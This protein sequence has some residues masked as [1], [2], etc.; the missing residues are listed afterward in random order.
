MLGISFPPV[1]IF[2]SSFFG[3]ALTIHLVL[4]SKNYRQFFLR[5][6]FIFTVEQLIAIS[7]I[8]ISGLQ[9]HAD[10]FL[11]L[12]G[13]VTII[14]HSLFL[15][16][17][18]LIFFFVSRNIKISRFP[19]FPL[20]FFPFIW[21]AF[22]YFH[23]LG[24]VSFPW[25]TLGNAFTTQLNKIQFTE[26]TGVFGISFWVCII[27]ALIYYLVKES[28]KIETKSFIPAFTRRKNIIIYVI[29]IV[30]Y[31]LPDI[32]SIST[33]SH[34]KYTD[35]KK[36][37]VLK[38]GV[39]QPNYNPWTKWTMNSKTMTDEYAA[40]IRDLTSA[41]KNLDLIVMP[42]ASINYYLLEPY[43]EPKL[44]IFTN[45]VDS[46]NI[47]LLCGGPDLKIWTDTLSAPQDAPKYNDSYKYSSY[48]G[49]FLIEKGN[50]V[51]DIQKYHKMRLVA[52]S[53]RIPHQEYLKFLKNFI[54]WEVGISSYEIGKDTTIFKLSG[55]NKFNTAIC[56]ESIYPDF[57]RRFVK[58]G[59]EFSVV[60]T[61]DGW[62]GK[63]FGTY[64]HNQFAILRAVENRRWIV[65][66][67]NTGISC[68]IDPYGNMTNKTEIGERVWFA[69]EI[70]VNNAKTFYTENGDLIGE[71]SFYLTLVL[72][73]SG[74][75]MRIYF[76]VLRRKSKRQL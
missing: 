11:A 33:S 41:N 19:N 44:R 56:Y 74:I 35:Y 28:R 26:Y 17:P 46:L 22:E 61:N 16:I 70:G 65:R 34:D 24:E 6:Y 7:W 2:F 68:I 55:K 14:I 36:D 23:S 4:D 64:Q 69:S 47:P 63:F 67:A 42:E 58:K 54:T 72:I 30:L 21:V 12:G 25:L 37:G 27:A 8:S 38:V 10:L 66:C 57:F 75:V 48:N 15:L 13:A 59:A 3:L 60:I 51:N 52:G 45:L 20:I 32:Y 50:G 71:F 5:S 29:L 73:C 1:N 49:A 18:A 53:E 39:I 76:A 62:W 43:N 40:A 9:K 31:I